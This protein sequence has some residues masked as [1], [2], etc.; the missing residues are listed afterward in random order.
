MKIV[1]VHHHVLPGK[2]EAAE[3]RVNT[4]TQRMASQDGM[5]FRHVGKREDMPHCLTSVT[6]WRNAEAFAAWDAHRVTL[7]AIG[8]DN[9]YEKIEEYSLVV[10]DSQ[11]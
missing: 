10:S 2:L 5:L 1:I 9:P 6:G 7:P 3:R 8:G 11:D 4:V